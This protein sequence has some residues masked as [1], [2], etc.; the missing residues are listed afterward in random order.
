M[1]IYSVGHST[2]D[3]D[4]FLYLL[5]KYQ[6]MT[7]ADVRSMPGS[8]RYPQFNQDVM[9]EWLPEFDISYHHIPALG[10]RRKVEGEGY[11]HI[12][13]KG[14]RAYAQYTNTPYFRDGLVELLQLPRPVAF[15]CAESLW[16]KCHRRVIAEYLDICFPSIGV[17]HIMPDGSLQPVGMPMLRQWDKKQKERVN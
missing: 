1:S 9:R 14:F 5:Q 7:L 2:L 4:E 11:E 17:Q 15:M 10:G 8:N 16:W 3:Q 12:K 6:V 13:T